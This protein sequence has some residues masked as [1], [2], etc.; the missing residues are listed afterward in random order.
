MLP[1]REDEELPAAVDLLR[2]RLIELRADTLRQLTAALPVVDTGL[3]AIAAN[4]SIVID[5][6][7]AGVAEQE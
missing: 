7:D 2:T 4:A 3:L 1:V 5:A 6:L